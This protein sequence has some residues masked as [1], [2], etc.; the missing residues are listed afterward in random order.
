M[1]PVFT[2]V[3]SAVEIQGLLRKILDGKPVTVPTEAP[4][5]VVAAHRPVTRYD[6]F[7]GA[8][9]KMSVMRRARREGR[10]IVKHEFGGALAAPVRLLERVNLLPK[11]DDLLFEFR[12]F[13]VSG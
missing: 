12:E 1:D 6:V 7:D 9:K 2:N 10:A 4:L 13:D 11:F 3:R 5:D 8:R